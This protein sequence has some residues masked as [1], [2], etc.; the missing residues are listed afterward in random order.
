MV[1][2]AEAVVIIFFVFFTDLFVGIIQFRTG[3][4]Q[5][6][7]GGFIG[8]SLLPGWTIRFAV[9]IEVFVLFSLAID[10]LITFRGVP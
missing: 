1:I 4:I 6:I 10:I 7:T 5:V 2:T 9:D 3:Y 8:F